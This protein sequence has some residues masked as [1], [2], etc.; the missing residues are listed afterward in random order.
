MNTQVMFSSK[1]DMWET[2]QDFFEK[3]NEEFHFTLDACAT[4]KK[5]KCESFFTNRKWMLCSTLCPP[6]TC[7]RMCMGSGLTQANTRKSDIALG[8]ALRSICT[9]TAKLITIFA[10]LVAQGW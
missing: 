6:Q 2:P 9:H 1:T 8:V 3:L 10:R 4:P 5:A 7:G